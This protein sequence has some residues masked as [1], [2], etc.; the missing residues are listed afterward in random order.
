MRLVIVY[1][2]TLSLGGVVG[3]GIAELVGIWFP[4][5]VV[6]VFVAVSAYWLYTGWR[7]A[8]WLSGRR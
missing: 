5:A 7:H 1:I 4:K 2:L 3:F 6:P 8:N